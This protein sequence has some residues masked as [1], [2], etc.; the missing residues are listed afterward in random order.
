MTDPLYNDIEAEQKAL[1]NRAIKAIR[2]FKAQCRMSTLGHIFEDI[3]QLK[4]KRSHVHIYADSA[5]ILPHI[6][7]TSYQ[8][9]K[10]H[11][12]VI[13]AINGKPKLS[14]IK[15]ILELLPNDNKIR[16]YEIERILAEIKKFTDEMKEIQYH[17]MKRGSGE[18]WLAEIIDGNCKPILKPQVFSLQFN[19][20]GS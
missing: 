17:T 16:Y 13:S 4:V 19:L 3:V 5:K 15:Q 1:Y 7:D 9:K 2:R 8:Y 14:S 11:N 12:I 20:D 18:Q 10:L 6:V